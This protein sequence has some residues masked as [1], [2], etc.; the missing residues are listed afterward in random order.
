[1]VNVVVLVEAASEE[2]ATR[3]MPP[4]RG[5]SAGRMV[6]TTSLCVSTE[7]DGKEWHTLTSKEFSQND[8]TYCIEDSTN[9]LY[10][11]ITLQAS[12][13]RHEDSCYGA[14]RHTRSLR[15]ENYLDWIL[16]CCLVPNIR[17]WIIHATSHHNPRVDRTT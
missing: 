8:R 12:V 5:K 7:G 10:Q 16:Q 14:D 6:R 3:R 17:P 1:M 13:M 11:N 4:P 15:Q 2:A 9:K